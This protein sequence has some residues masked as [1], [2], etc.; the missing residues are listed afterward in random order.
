MLIE[1]NMEREI[2]LVVEIRK[3]RIPSSVHYT[4]LTISKPLL[5]E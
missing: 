3:G 4:K 1:C 5:S 2:E